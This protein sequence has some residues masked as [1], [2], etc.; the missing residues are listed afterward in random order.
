MSKEECHTCGEE[1]EDKC[2]FCSMA[3]PFCSQ[4][5][6]DNYMKYEGSGDGQ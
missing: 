4:E 6:Y 1:F 5:C 2:E 3:Y